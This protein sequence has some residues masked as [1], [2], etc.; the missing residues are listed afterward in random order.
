MH[1]IACYW[2]GFHSETKKL[3]CIRQNSSDLHRYSSLGRK[4][5]IHGWGST[6]QV[7]QEIQ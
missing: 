1:H 7:H 5:L 2:E 6:R 3:G 4:L